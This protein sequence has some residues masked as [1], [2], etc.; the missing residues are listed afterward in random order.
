[1]KHLL[2]LLS[3][4]TGMYSLMK[5]DR[6]LFFFLSCSSSTGMQGEHGMYAARSAATRGIRPVVFAADISI[7]T[8]SS[9]DMARLGR[10]VT[11]AFCEWDY[12]YNTIYI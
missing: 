12:N 2:V 8:T 4:L 3:A 1:M 6:M 5:W 7:P 10:E 11:M 9:T